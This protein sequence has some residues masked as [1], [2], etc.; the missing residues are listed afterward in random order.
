MKMWMSVLA[1]LAIVLPAWG[2]VPREAGG[3][4]AVG[5]GGASMPPVTSMP[6][7]GSGG[8]GPI[9][10]AIGNVVGPAAKDQAKGTNGE[11][12]RSQRRQ[13]GSVPEC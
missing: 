1:V 9:G 2:E 5:G 12:C 6:G 3:A 11:K 13:G 8:R 10:S 7:Q 4:G